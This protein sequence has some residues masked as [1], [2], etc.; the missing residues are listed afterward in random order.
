MAGPPAKCLNPAC[1]HVFVMSGFFGGP[2]TAANIHLQGNVTNCPRCGSPAAMGDGVYEYSGGELRLVNG[3]PLTRAM[4]AKLAEITQAAKAKRIEA[5]EL[6]AE[7]A[8]VSP[9]LAQKLRSHGFGYFAIML[10]LIWLLKSVSLE[11][12]IDLNE[13]IDQAREVS[14]EVD[15]PS[16]LDAPL[17]YTQPAPREP[18]YSIAADHSE[19]PVSR[20]VRRQLERQAKKAAKSGGSGRTA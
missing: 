6:L 3:P 18:S 17:P 8:D 12:K 5:E 1:Q 15:D 4:V 9:E 7:V 11:I 2:G 14:S 20:Q 19:A 10:L 13:L 16:I